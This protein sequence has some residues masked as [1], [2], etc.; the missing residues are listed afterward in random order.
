MKLN[1]TNM[2]GAVIQAFFDGLD[3][4]D[5]IFYSVASVGQILAT[6]ATDGLALVGE[7]AMQLATFAY[8]VEDS[9][10]AIAA[11]A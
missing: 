6:L 8:L 10:K 2:L 5:C 3:W 7:I 9:N 1:T 4:Y 11:C